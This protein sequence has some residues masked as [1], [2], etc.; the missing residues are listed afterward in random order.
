MATKELKYDLH[1]LRY[2]GVIGTGGI[3][4]GGTNGSAGFIEVP[5]SNSGV[6]YLRNTNLDFLT[7]GTL[8]FDNGISRGKK[9]ITI[10]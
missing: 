10:S 9:L 7:G 8:H 6:I 2:T 5:E 4:E 1:N 3:V